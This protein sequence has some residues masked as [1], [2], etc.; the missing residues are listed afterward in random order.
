[1]RHTQIVVKCA[2]I[3]IARQKYF[4]ATIMAELMQIMGAHERASKEDIEKVFTK[5]GRLY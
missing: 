2:L 3:R 1:M 4:A 5:V